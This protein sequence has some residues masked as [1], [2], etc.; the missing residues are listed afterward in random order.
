MVNNG[1]S[2]D[3]A[4]GTLLPVKQQNDDREVMM[5]DSPTQESASFD[6]NEYKRMIVQQNNVI[7]KLNQKIDNIH[8]SYQKQNNEEPL[9]DQQYIMVPNNVRQQQVTYVDNSFEGIPKNRLV[10]LGCGVFLLY[11]FNSLKNRN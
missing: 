3:E 9:N 1:C 11:I 8:H 5:D 7:N 4:W 2:L 6:E 10:L